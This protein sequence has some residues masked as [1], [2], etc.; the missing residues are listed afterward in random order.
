[1]HIF[2]KWRYSMPGLVM[3]VGP[4]EMKH[5]NDKTQPDGSVSGGPLRWLE[6]EMAQVMQPG[7]SRRAAQLI[8]MMRSV[9]RC[10]L[11]SG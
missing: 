11:T 10:R 2:T 4:L 5:L 3:K 7:R 6:D 8:T 1:M 9:R